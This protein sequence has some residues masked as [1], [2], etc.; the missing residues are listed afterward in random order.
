M[1][2]CF[3][4]DSDSIKHVEQFRPFT[5]LSMLHK[6]YAMML[7]ILCKPYFVF[8]GYLQFGAR[9]EHSCI[10]IIFLLR[11]M[12]QK[13]LEWKISLL[14]VSLDLVKA[15]DSLS[16]SAI[17]KYIQEMEQSLPVR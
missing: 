1:H 15:F 7:F 17:I 12:I 3:P 5:I 16:L 6:L 9:P 14:I 4:K 2:A 13:C 8:K 11:I 10:E